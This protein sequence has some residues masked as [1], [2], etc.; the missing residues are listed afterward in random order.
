MNTVNLALMATAALGGAVGGMTLG[1]IASAIVARGNA[2]FGK[3]LT[4]LGF[5]GGIAAGIAILPPFLD[6]HLRP[7]FEQIIGA[8]KAQEP[9][10]LSSV[11]QL[12]DLDP[13]EVSAKVDA[14]IAD[15]NDPF[16]MAVLSK[17]PSRAKNFETQLGL[18]YRRG[19]DEALRA[20]ATKLVLDVQTQAMPFYMARA[21]APDLVVAMSTV[22]DT[23]KF[24]SENDPVVCHRWLYGHQSG[25]L[26]D[27]A[28]YR[29]VLGDERHLKL[30]QSL[31]NAVTGAS[32]ILPEYD[33]KIASDILIQAQQMALSE[34]GDD[35][36]GI[37][38][39]AQIPEG[40]AEAKQA[41][42]TTAA[43]YEM[44]LSDENAATAWR[45]FFI[46]DFI[47]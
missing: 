26:V 11:E 33:E 27:Y 17:E 28:R 5:A 19:G 37:I 10:G 16:F 35:K 34:L 41:C 39:G 43:I 36:I 7:M 31:A 8:P 42:D 20:E 44:I 6:P 45:H 15:L 1:M 3:T 46:H 24:L 32:E 38:S 14:M 21:Q 18:A 47:L 22:R 29:A 4:F 2:G 9:V 40:A 12:P 23:I 25:N 13:L 30:Q